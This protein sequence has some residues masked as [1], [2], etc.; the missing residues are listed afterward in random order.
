MDVMVVWKGERLMEV[1]KMQRTKK[2]SEM[3]V[4]LVLGVVTMAVLADGCGGEVVVV[5]LKHS[6]D[7]FRRLEHEERK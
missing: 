2:N 1:R 7:T 5:E 4:V 3:C 6:S